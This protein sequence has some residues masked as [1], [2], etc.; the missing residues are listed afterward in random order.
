MHSRSWPVVLVEEP[1]DVPEGEKHEAE[2]EGEIMK[3]VP[4][5]RV[6]GVVAE[7]ISATFPSTP[8]QGEPRGTPL[9]NSSRTKR[10]SGR[11]GQRDGSGHLQCETVL[12]P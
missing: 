3:A 4:N 7:A 8:T 2:A 6:G 1:T 5:H 9:R 11:C 10:F 12:I